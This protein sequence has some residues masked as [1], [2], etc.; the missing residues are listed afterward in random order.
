MKTKHGNKWFSKL[1]AQCLAVVM[2]MSLGMTVSA[3]NKVPE[4]GSFTVGGFDTEPIPTVTAYQIIEVN[5]DDQG[6]PQN[7]MYRWADEVADWVGKY[8]S[9]YIDTDNG[10]AVTE[11]FE[12]PDAAVMTAFLEKLAAAIETSAN[13]MGLTPIMGTITNGTAAFNNVSIG[14][15]LLTA[16]DGV[17]IYQPTT[18]QLIPE[19]D[20]PDGW[21]LTT[22]VGN[23]GPDAVMKSEEP[24]IDKDVTGDSNQP[25][26]SDDHTVAVGDTVTFRLDVTVPSYPEDAQGKTFIISDTPGRGLA[27]QERTVKVY[28]DEDLSKVITDEYYEIYLPW[29]GHDTS[30]TF[31]ID[32]NEKFFTDYGALTK[33]Y[34]TYDVEVTSDAFANGGMLKNDAFLGYNNDPYMEN[35]YTEIPTDEKVY[36]YTISLEKVDS[37]GNPITENPATFQLEDEEGNILYFN[38]ADGVYTYDSGNTAATQGARSEL[39]TSSAGT[40]ELKGLDTGTYTL[41][42]TSAPNGYVVPGGRITIKLEDTQGLNGAQGPDG[43]LDGNGLVVSSGD[44]QLGEMTGGADWEIDGTKIS[45]K[46]KNTSSDDA[47]FQLPKTGGMGTMIFTVAGILLMGGAVALVVMAARRKRD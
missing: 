29:N 23:G 9:T 33:I 30:R 42:E 14:E 16:K 39:V 5:L 4:T 13:H 40:L 21:K 35:G 7:P 34:V 44:P 27:F 37:D 46:V 31:A 26:S 15:Y 2:V 38:G 1:I 19:Y 24:D 6:Q 25:G 45:F 3:A 36:T 11:A 12:N 47:G 10:N 41:T 20:E 17:K 32:F 22:T 43:T 18:V 28:A 8:E